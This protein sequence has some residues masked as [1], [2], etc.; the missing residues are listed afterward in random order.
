MNEYEDGPAEQLEQ[1]LADYE[2]RQPSAAS[3]GYEKMEVIKGTKPLAMYE[4]ISV[5]FGSAML[6]R[7]NKPVWVE[8]QNDEYTDCLTVKQAESMAAM[9]PECDWRIHLI[10]PLSE[11]YYQRQGN[12]KWVMYEKGK[13]FA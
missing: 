9:Y 11:F 13:G 3:A 7:D 4:V 12:E 6:L 8:S 2:K 1:E 5:G 10:G